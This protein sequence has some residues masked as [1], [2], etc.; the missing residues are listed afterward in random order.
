M[1]ALL[2][3]GCLATT[4][5]VAIAADCGGKAPAG[6]ACPD[7]GSLRMLY[8]S[9]QPASCESLGLQCP[10]TYQ[11]QCLDVSGVAECIAGGWTFHMQGGDKCC[12]A[13]EP[14]SGGACQ[15]PAG[16]NVYPCGYG[17]N[18]YYFCMSGSWCRDWGTTDGGA[19]LCP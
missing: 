11:D 5:L 14:A 8:L 16:A 13:N 6:D 3:V 12:P 1:N 19:P 4:A 7:I 18:N 15:W 2:V 9:G 10:L 17:A